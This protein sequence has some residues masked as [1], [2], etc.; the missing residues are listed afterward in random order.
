MVAR[1]VCR[2]ACRSFPILTV[3]VVIFPEA[4]S[5]APCRGTQ[6]GAP[7]FLSQRPVCSVHR[8]SRFTR[9]T[10]PV[11]RANFTP[12]RKKIKA[13]GSAT[14][15]VMLFLHKPELQGIVKDKKIR[16]KNDHRNGYIVY[17]SQLIPRRNPLCSVQSP[18]GMPHTSNQ[19][20][21]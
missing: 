11:C 15:R 6:A 19:T 2:E 13:A 21:A 1:F 8:R 14:L 12:P 17:D 16:N 3:S 10:V 20:K 18:T 5:A 9:F 7:D 4:G